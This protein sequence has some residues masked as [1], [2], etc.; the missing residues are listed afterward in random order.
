MKTQHC[1]ITLILLITF[2]FSY[3]QKC[4][5]DEY[6]DQ[7]KLVDK[8]I[9]ENV[10]TVVKSFQAKSNSSDQTII[11]PVIFNVIH[12]GE[13]I[14]NGKNLSRQKILE[15]INILNEAYAGAYG[16][17]DTKIKFCLAEKDIYGNYTDGVNR[18]FGPSYFDTG[19]DVPCNPKKVSLITDQK[20]KSYRKPGFPTNQYLNLWTTDI[21]ACD[22]NQDLGYSSFPFIRD[23]NKLD[24]VVIDYYYVG[25]SDNS[26]VYNLGKT[27]VHEIGHWLGLFHTFQYDSCSSNC[28]TDGDMICD[29]EGVQRQAHY[30][31]QDACLGYNCNNQ[32]TNA[33]QNFM[34][35][36]RD[37]C[38]TFFTQGQKDRMRNMLSL[39]KPMIYNKESNANGIVSCSGVPPGTG[40]T[41]GGC[42]I[43]N[44]PVQSIYPPNELYTV[45]WLNEFGGRIEVNDKWLITTDAKADY[46]LIYERSGCAYN[47]KQN[48]AIDFYWSISADEG[49]ILRD[50]EIIVSSW[51]D[52]KVYIYNYNTTSDQWYLKQTIQNSSATS[53][54]GY[55]VFTL[56][57]FLFV[58]EASDTNNI[59][60]IYKKDSNGNYQFH[61]NFSVPGYNLSSNS[62]HYTVLNYSK[63]KRGNYDPNEIFLPLTNKLFGILELNSSNQW[64]LSET[65]QM[66]FI[67]SEEGFI[68][69]ELSNNYLYMVTKKDYRTVYDDIYLYTIPIQSDNIKQSLTGTISNRK[70]FL[71]KYNNASYSSKLRVF[72][73]QFFIFGPGSHGGFSYLFFTNTKYGQNVTFPEWQQ[74]DIDLEC[75]SDHDSD[76]E[77]YGN[78]LFSGL[79]DKH[80]INVYDMYDILSSMGYSADYIYD[81][82]FY[83]YKNCSVPKLKVSYFSDEVTFGG[84]CNV[85]F[86]GVHKDI[87][88]RKAI[89]LKPGTKI[90]SGSTVSFTLKNQICNSIISSHNKNNASIE[91]NNEDLSPIKLIS[92]QE[93]VNSNPITIYPTPTQNGFVHVKSRNVNIQNIVIYNLFGKLDLSLNELNLKN[94][95]EI[96]IN[97]SRY[98][99]GI[100]LIKISM[101]DNNEVIKRILIE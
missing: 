86:D 6:L 40:G 100:Y 66:D 43:G 36:A 42:T 31:N 91:Q 5:S 30:S 10:K 26:T 58:L 81:S 45:D 50:N 22:N 37:E 28:D 49:L 9:I 97:L 51:T 65:I 47:L 89:N 39:Y 53:K 21:R 19:S 4:L 48:F 7:Y 77:V 35:Y 61:Q 74:K 87:S 72:G 88:A 92:N 46:L 12:S 57:D 41:P 29:T 71:K 83:K 13:S 56:D 68:T 14:G 60:R 95:K 23:N 64:Y 11:I 69:S 85:I 27:A 78:L 38:Q 82:A 20:I 17:V 99:K 80:K 59:I 33:I 44:T 76:Y 24:G 62:S 15:Q 52:D 34:D 90:K 1:I 55:D 101:I 25:K 18:Y 96:D 2:S 16:G 3:S 75:F 94:P 98:P 93:D 63:V 79:G 84:N 8:N 54:V 67:S 70:Q 32:V 73:D